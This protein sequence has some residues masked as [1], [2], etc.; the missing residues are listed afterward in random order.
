MSSLQPVGKAN[1]KPKRLNSAFKQLMTIHWWM[2]LCYLVLFVVGTFMTQLPR[3]V[4]LRSPLYNF[5][6][7]MGV[8]TIALLSWRILV[9]MRVWWR[10]YIKKLPKF[11]NKWFKN[12]AVHA[13]L[14][15]FM[16]VVPMT[17]FFLSNSYKSN[18]VKFFGIVLPDIFPENSAMVELGRS[19]HFWFSYT[20]LAFIL[21]HII[22]QWKVVRA[23]W[24]RFTIFVG[25]HLAIPD[26][27]S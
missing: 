26:R 27:F 6:K 10:K 7:S 11:T 4:S 23:N 15:L 18:N 3:E 12:F 1:L 20:F 14:Y 19:M 2:A 5:H 22:L 17:G 9:L 24:K 21:L 25:K 16:W 8:L 13:T